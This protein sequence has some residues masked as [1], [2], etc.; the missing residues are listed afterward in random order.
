MSGGSSFGDGPGRIGSKLQ[1][2][3]SKDL[4]QSNAG[5]YQIP[6][7]SGSGFG[8]NQQQ[9]HKP[10]ALDV[11]LADYT[12]AETKH[13]LSKLSGSQ[14]SLY[15]L[16]QVA[17][18]IDPTGFEKAV[19]ATVQVEQGQ[20]QWA[21]F[22]LSELAER[23]STDIEI[24]L[25]DEMVLLNREL[26]GPNVLDEPA[27]DPWWKI[28][29]KNMTTPVIL[30]LLVAAAVCFAFQ[31]WAEAAVILVVVLANGAMSTYMEK[32]AGDAL[33]A[34]ASLAAPRCLVRRGGLETEVD[35]TEVVPGDLLLLGTGDALAADVRVVETADLHT[36][37]AILTGEPD[38]VKKHIVASNPASAFAD[39]LCF[40]STNI[41]SGRG[42]GLVY[43]TGMQ[44][45]VGRI[46]EQLTSASRGSTKTPLQAALDKLGG[47]IGAAAVGALI[48]VVGVAILIGYQDP[49]HPDANPILSVRCLVRSRSHLQI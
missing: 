39:N 43:A 49:S 3:L 18:S 2:K 20:N 7:A 38:D 19:Q 46:A 42:L 31:E 29:F 30:I 21:I 26:Y 33:A 24:G 34:L 13:V 36:N 44:T 8:L 47:W 16:V 23:Y 10:N 28:L 41:V 22:P 48:V 9:L 17:R 1:R 15:E 12:D 45:Q 37:E 6:S 40:A 25:T 32:S 35:A 27:R 14:I 4:P 11:A 5:S